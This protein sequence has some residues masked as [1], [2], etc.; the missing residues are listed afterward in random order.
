MLILVHQ[1]SFFMYDCS[2]VSAGLYFKQT[3]AD[4]VCVTAPGEYGWSG[5]LS[6]SEEICVPSE[7]SYL[8]HTFAVTSVDQ[9]AFSFCDGL[10]KITLPASVKQLLPYAFSECGDLE[11]IILS[12]AIKVIGVGCF[13]NCERLSYARMPAQL[14][15]VEIDAF[16]M[17]PSLHELVLPDTVVE[18]GDGAFM[19]CTGLWSFTI[20]PKVRRIRPHTFETCT[21]LTH[22]A[23]PQGVEQIGDCAF[24]NC[25]NL[26]TISIPAT[27]E[28]IG[29]NSFALCGN[30]KSLPLPD[31]FIRVEDKDQTPVFKYVDMWFAMD[32]SDSS[33][34]WL[35]YSL[36]RM[37]CYSGNV[38]VPAQ[39]Q[40]QGKTFRVIGVSSFAFAH[41]SQLTT[42]SLPPTVLSIGEQAFSLCSALTSVALPA[43]LQQI[44]KWAF[45]MCR[46]LQHLQCSPSANIDRTAFAECTALSGFDSFKNR[47]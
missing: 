18:I 23:L 46:S 6:P 26:L 5:I 3:D 11:S 41:S 44:G 14:K 34:V 17:C 42:V 30:L 38:E 7:V 43:T 22:L 25:A 35:T 16:L 45:A 31:H 47:E 36:R 24:L 2:F 9:G 4:Q 10:R 20:P 37:A 15:E 21:S 13:S 32:P 29:A 19:D 33:A 28:E 8:G 40:F 12:D 39:V 27:V 1:H